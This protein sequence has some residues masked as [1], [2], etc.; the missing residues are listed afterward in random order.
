MIRKILLLL[1]LFAATG[2]ASAYFYYG[3]DLREPLREYR[4]AEKEAS[5]TNYNKAWE[6]RGYIVGVYD[7]T[8][9]EYC[10]PSDFTSHQLMAIVAKYI[11]DNP[12]SWSEPASNLVKR[13]IK[14]AFPCG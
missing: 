5:D 9:L 1:A 6:F 2:N 7:A 13:A 14:S 3:N 10:T 11:E 12:Q 8:A 4:N